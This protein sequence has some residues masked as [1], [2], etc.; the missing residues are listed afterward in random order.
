MRSRRRPVSRYLLRERSIMRWECLRIGIPTRK[1]PSD[2]VQ[3]RREWVIG[4]DDGKVK[5]PVFLT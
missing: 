3:G 4:G 5:I 1:K 2:P